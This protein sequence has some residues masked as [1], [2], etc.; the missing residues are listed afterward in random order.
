MFGQWRRIVVSQWCPQSKMSANRI[1]SQFYWQ[2]D[3]RKVNGCWSPKGSKVR[4][5]NCQS[6]IQ[7]GNSWNW[8]E[9]SQWCPSRSTVVSNETIFDPISGPKIGCLF[10]LTS[11]NRQKLL[12]TA[13]LYQ[14]IV[15]DRSKIIVVFFLGKFLFQNF[16]PRFESSFLSLY[17]MLVYHV[18]HALYD[19]I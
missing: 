3:W 11:T 6:D 18:Y 4:M 17:H 13:L 10:I 14:T 2:S 7:C 12:N 15:N 19:H 1:W 8:F 9:F 5:H 16:F